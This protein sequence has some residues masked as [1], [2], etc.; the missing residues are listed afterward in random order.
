MKCHYDVLGVDREGTIPEIKR[1]FYQQVIA[2]S[3]SHGRYGDKKGFPLL[4]PFRFIPSLLMDDL[5][6]ENK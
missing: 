1:A 5:W 3:I 6:L 4:P 2:L